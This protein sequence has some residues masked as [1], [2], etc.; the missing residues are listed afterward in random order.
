MD[1]SWGQ[2]DALSDIAEVYA[3][4]KMDAFTAMIGRYPPT[5]EALH[6]VASFLRRRCNP[7]IDREKI[8]KLATRKLEYPADLHECEALAALNLNAGAV[9][10]RLDPSL[11]ERTGQYYASYG[12]PHHPLLRSGHTDHGKMMEILRGLH[13]DSGKR[14]AED[15][16]PNLGN[17]VE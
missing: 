4:A 3:S 5:L 13:Q 15:H 12:Y 14:W 9:I 8:R 16:C 10:A 2:F 7:K 11:V 6:V 17:L 1:G